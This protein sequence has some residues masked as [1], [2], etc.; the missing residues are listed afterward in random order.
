M[1][2]IHSH[3]IRASL[4]RA[5]QMMNPGRDPY[6]ESRSSKVRGIEFRPGLRVQIRH[7]LNLPFHENQEISRFPNSWGLTLMGPETSIRPQFQSWYGG[8]RVAKCFSCGAENLG[9]AKF[10]SFCGRSMAV[11]PSESSTRFR[12]CV[13]C[14]RMI[15]WNA[16]LNS[17]F[18]LLLCL[19]RAPAE[20][21]YGFKAVSGGVR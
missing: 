16:Q 13:S 20:T 14:G 7:H 21:I 8:A 11:V 17:F 10:C 15:D 12:T 3:E 6:L 18:G 1:N 5:A 19:F 2:P 4:M 9:Q